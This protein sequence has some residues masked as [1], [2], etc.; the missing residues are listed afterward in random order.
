MCERDASVNKRETS[1]NSKDNFVDFL[2]SLIYEIKRG[3]RAA[4]VAQLF[5]RAAKR[6]E[7]L[8][9]GSAQNKNNLRVF[10]IL[11]KRGFLW[12]ENCWH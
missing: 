5:C 11:Q 2:W 8:L 7:K 1:L 10:K 3:R 9:N 6:Y 4:I 12:M